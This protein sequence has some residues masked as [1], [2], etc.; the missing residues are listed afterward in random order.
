MEVALPQT[1][2][3]RRSASDGRGAL[4]PPG[5]EA[6]SR[7]PAAHGSPATRTTPPGDRPGA[8]RRAPR[9]RPS[10]T[11]TFTG[12]DAHTSIAAASEL[13]A[14]Y[15]ATEFAVL[16]GG[17]TGRADAHRFPSR[18]VLDNGLKLPPNTK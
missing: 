6:T 16:V 3:K 5:P 15:P 4:H 14:R 13:H 11:L 1:P 8:G 9:P 17:R 18:R 7:Y 12:V 10:E 2:G